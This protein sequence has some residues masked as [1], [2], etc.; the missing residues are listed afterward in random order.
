MSNQMLE[1]THS[2]VARIVDLHQ[3]SF[4]QAQ[5]S[6]ELA[7]LV[8]A[9]Q[10]VIWSTAELLLEPQLGMAQIAQLLIEEQLPLVVLLAF[11]E[12]QV[13]V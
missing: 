7:P 8:F 3:A 5:E 12:Q 9:Y 4:A 2:L 1:V 10:F 6:L 13:M 11:G